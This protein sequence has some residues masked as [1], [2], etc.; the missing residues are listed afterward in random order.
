MKEGTLM[1]RLIAL[2]LACALGACT[3]VQRFTVGDLANA[4]TLAG[5]SDPT[6]AQCWAALELAAAA[7]PKPSDDGL[8]TLAE[9]ERLA[10]LAVAGACGAIIAPALLQDIGKAVPAPIN[11]ALPF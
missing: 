11:L 6:G 3:Q 5:Q 9:R 7:T 8:A 10:Q 4:A 1:K 2:T